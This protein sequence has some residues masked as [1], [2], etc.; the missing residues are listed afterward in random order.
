MVK[1]NYKKP[2]RNQDSARI[3]DQGA[4]EKRGLRFQAGRVLGAR[5]QRGLE[6]PAPRLPRGH[7]LRAER[8]LRR[9]H[10]RYQA[11]QRND[12]K[13]DQPTWSIYL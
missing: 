10:D 1:Q 7:V 4:G 2:Q 13:L 6:H 3:R 11:S 12:R 8:G 9:C 5:A